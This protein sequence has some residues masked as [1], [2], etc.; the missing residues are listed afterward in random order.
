[1]QQ[2][3]LITFDSSLKYFNAGALRPTMR[4]RRCLYFPRCCFNRVRV[5]NNRRSHFV[6]QLYVGVYRCATL[7][8]GIQGIAGRKDPGNL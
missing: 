7:H 1:M 6:N 3:V 5:I 4:L 8:D 2:V